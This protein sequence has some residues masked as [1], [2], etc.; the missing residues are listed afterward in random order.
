MMPIIG[1]LRFI[2]CSTYNK[3]LFLLFSNSI[4][5]LECVSCGGDI[6]DFSIGLVFHGFGLFQLKTLDLLFY[7]DSCKANTG[8]EL[9]TSS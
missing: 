8:L 9:L 5:S 1:H 4:P 2:K 7:L 6:P 3:F